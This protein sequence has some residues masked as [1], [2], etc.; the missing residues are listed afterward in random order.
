[1]H[2]QIAGILAREPEPDRVDDIF[3]RSDGNAFF[4][5][6]LAVAADEGCRTGLTDSLRDLL[7]VRVENLPESAQRVV[8]I[9]AEEAPPSRTG[10]SPPSP[11]SARTT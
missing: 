10:C 5:E 6:E 8:R 11:D 1:M 9:V 4:V 3:E 2:R 7:L